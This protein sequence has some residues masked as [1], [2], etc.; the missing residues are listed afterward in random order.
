MCT[1]P[2]RDR[3]LHYFTAIMSPLRLLSESLIRCDTWYNL[4]TVK[5]DDTKPSRVFL[6]DN[7][8]LRYRS[9]QGNPT[10]QASLSRLPQSLYKNRSETRYVPLQAVQRSVELILIAGVRARVRV[11]PECRV[12]TSHGA[13][14]ISGLLQPHRRRCDD[15]RPAGRE[16][17]DA[18]SVA[19]DP[20]RVCR[21]KRGAVARAS[22]PPVRRGVDDWLYMSMPL[23]GGLRNGGRERLAGVHARGCVVG[24]REVLDPG[25]HR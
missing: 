3:D 14:W 13:R 10:D 6:F 24:V 15:V 2:L 4:S 23:L 22:L 21:R 11:L 20:E 8:W 19:S 12:S 16:C 17:A 1:G 18:R 7:I 9:T 25:D 5:L